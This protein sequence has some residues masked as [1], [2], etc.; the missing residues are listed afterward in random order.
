MEVLYPRCAG[1]DVHKKTAVV[2]VITPKTEGGF[3]RQVRTFTTLTVGLL[4]M[5]DWFVECGCSH[6]AMESTGEYWRPIYNILE[7]NVEVLLVNARHLKTVPGRKTDVKDAEWIAQLL[8]HGLLQAS[9]I[10]PPEQRI[11]RDFTR[12]RLNFI[13]ERVNLVNRVQKV[14][15]GANIKLA[16]VASD[17]MGVSG[18]AMLAAL[19]EGTQT[20]AE[21]ADLAKGQL[22]FKR[23]QLEQALTGR[24]DA[25][26]RFILSELLCQIDAVEETIAR[27]D[28]QIEAQ[29]RPFEAAVERLDT[30]PG[31]ARRAAE[32]IVAEIGID[33]SR[34][35]SAAHLASWAGLVPG[36][37]ESAGKQRSGRTRKGNQTLRTL[38][39][40]VAYA[41]GRTQT[42]LGAQFRR[43]AARRGRKR[44]AVAVGH[45]ILVIAYHL[46]Q[47]GEVYQDLGAHYFESQPPEKT[48]QHL[49]KRLQQLGYQVTLQPLP[50][51]LA[52]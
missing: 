26:H 41:A 24:V 46:I 20:P 33:M 35:P 7:G 50:F 30:I 4:A 18:R 31:I 25:H 21:M 32:V 5:L 17:I 44:A 52:S 16:S 47:R 23:D 10:P 22:R 27:F 19:L 40:Q 34:F 11:L 42:Y 51:P 45:S 15:E 14:L 43:L 8:Q 38:L 36:N 37:H 29:C 2:C 49:V 28:A 13:R 1:I 48:K 3:E 6:V 12:H 9:F 39:I